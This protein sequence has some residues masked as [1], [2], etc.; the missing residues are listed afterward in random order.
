MQKKRMERLAP[1][2]QVNERNHKANQE[3]QKK[4]AAAAAAT[5]SEVDP[6]TRRMTLPGIGSTLS[7]K[8]PA[9]AATT[10]TPT[11]AAPTAGLRRRGEG[12]D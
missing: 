12:I 7:K 9:P 8:P 2:L 3:R 4:I 1:V 11:A 10:A 6:F 5:V